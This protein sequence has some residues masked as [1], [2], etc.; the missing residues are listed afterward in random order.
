MKEKEKQKMG[1]NTDR[2]NWT[3]KDSVEQ[4]DISGQHCYWGPG[5][6]LGHA[7]IKDAMLTCWPCSNKDLLLL[8]ARWRS[9]V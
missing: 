2:W 7:D 6:V 1:H 4:P 8:K 5:E 3:V 9:L